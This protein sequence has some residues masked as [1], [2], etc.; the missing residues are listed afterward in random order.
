MSRIELQIE[1]TGKRSS[2]RPGCAKKTIFWHTVLFKIS[3]LLVSPMDISTQ[4]K[5]QNFIGRV[6][7]K[8]FLIYFIR[9]DFMHGSIWWTCSKSTACSEITL[10]KKKIRFSSYIRKFRMEQLQSH[11]W[12]TISS[13]I[14]KP[15]LIYDFAT[16]LG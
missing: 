7:W 12:L 6:M 14:R 11:I 16:A 15:F 10:I 3:K 5:I 2:V 1:R 13:Y 9:H 8:S 4:Y